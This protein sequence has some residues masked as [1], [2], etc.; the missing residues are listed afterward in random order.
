MQTDLYPHNTCSHTHTHHVSCS[1]VT[2]RSVNR[3]VTWDQACISSRCWRLFRTTA[4]TTITKSDTQT[5]I[6]IQRSNF[7]GHGYRVQTRLHLA[8]KSVLVHLVWI[9]RCSFRMTSKKER[10]F[11]LWPHELFVPVT[12]TSSTSASSLLQSPDL[13]LSVSKAA[14]LWEQPTIGVKH[15]RP[16]RS[17]LWK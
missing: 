15:K 5:H 13:I 4:L 1:F 14:E 12:I 17:W 7:V 9:N 8:V 6:H 11:R 10:W 2:R 16:S 3:L